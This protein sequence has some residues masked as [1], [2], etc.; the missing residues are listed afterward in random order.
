MEKSEIAAGFGFN[1]ARELLYFTMGFSSNPKIPLGILYW[2]LVK[3][4]ALFL[5]PEPL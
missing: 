3:K 5:C 2:V 1:V 4:V